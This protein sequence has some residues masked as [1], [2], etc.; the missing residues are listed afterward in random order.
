MAPF[1]IKLHCWNIITDAL[2][3]QEHLDAAAGCGPADTL[4][5]KNGSFFEVHYIYIYF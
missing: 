3:F 1:N 5:Y 2:T 4:L